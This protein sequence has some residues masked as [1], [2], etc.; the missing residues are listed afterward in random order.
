MTVSTGINRRE[1]LAAAGAL[2]LLSQSSASTSHAA[3]ANSGT[4]LLAPTPP[5]GWNSWNSFATTI[6]EEQAI[7][8]AE[9]MARELKPFGY[10]IFTIDIQWYEGAAKGYDYNTKPIPTMDEH[11]R[12]LPAPN[13]FPSSVKG[14]GFKPIADKVHAL[15]LKFGVHLM[16]GIPRLAVERNLPIFGGKWKARDIA[17]TASVC[18]WNPDMY[19]VDMS[20]PGAQE[21]YNSVFAL[22]ASWDIDFVKMDDMSRPYDANAPEIEAA[23][24]AIEASGR[25]MILSLSPGETPLA[26]GEHVRRYAQ[27]WRISDDFWDEWPQL[28]A[29]FT[30]LEN[31][32]MFRQPGRWPDADMLPLGRLQMGKRDCHFTPDEQRTL[33]TLWS[34]ARSPLIMGGDL[35]HLDPATLALL[36]NR[37]VLAVNQASRDNKPASLIE[38]VRTWTARAET[39]ETR[40]LA[41]FN[42]SDKADIKPVHFDLSRLG[43]KSAKVRDLW[44]QRD[45]GT[46]RDRVS[47][48]LAP[49]ACLLYG[50]TPV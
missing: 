8:N 49:H 37:E 16:R 33:M 46:V 40:Y 45:I 2:G 12:L 50:L 1:L 14:A 35:R 28:K 34:I 32:S 44:A 36:T 4:P 38:D 22:L 23:H 26:S 7:A 25:P 29:Q 27:M 47:A 9:I 30:R 15:A 18:P 6:T 3:S 24:R 11:G 17:N 21:Y 20:K 42:I 13:R 43:L 41:M 5:M 31:W 10:D 39:G 48:T 19:G